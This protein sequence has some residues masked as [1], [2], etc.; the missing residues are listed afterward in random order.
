MRHVQAATA[1][2]LPYPRLAVNSQTNLYQ[3][4]NRTL[5]VFAFVQQI[6][7]VLV[8]EFQILPGLFFILADFAF[9]VTPT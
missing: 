8:I 1:S 4:C 7:I 3:I 5:E 2:L 9:F 6:W